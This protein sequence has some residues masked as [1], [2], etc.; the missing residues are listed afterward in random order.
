MPEELQNLA[1]EV[2]ELRQLRD[3][4]RA[5]SD[6]ADRLLILEDQALPVSVRKLL[7]EI[8]AVNP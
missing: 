1:A 8:A 3:R 5:W 2:A 4:V 6:T 7:A